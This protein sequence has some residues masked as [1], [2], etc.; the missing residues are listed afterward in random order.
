MPRELIFVIC[1]LATSAFA[2]DHDALS[3]GDAAERAIQQSKLTLP[4]SEAFKLKAAIAEAG[5][6]TSDYRAE[7][8]EYW[9]SP[10]KWRR[11]IESPAFRRR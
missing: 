4:G 6:S 2:S 5:H 7:I 1:V 3:L 9:I 8:E 11:T 10:S